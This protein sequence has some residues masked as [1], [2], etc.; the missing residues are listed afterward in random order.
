M[1]LLRWAAGVTRLDKV[2]NEYIRDSYKVDYGGTSTLCGTV[3]ITENKSKRGR[4]A[5]TS[6]TTVAKDIK[7]ANLIDVTTQDRESWR[8]T[9]YK[10]LPRG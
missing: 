3:T 10:T 8:R 5:P 7:N 4:P 6:W 1:K 9:T 2:Q